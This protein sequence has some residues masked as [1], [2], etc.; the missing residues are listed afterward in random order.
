VNTAALLTAL[1]L[2]SSSLVGRSTLKEVLL[3][4]AAPTAADKRD[5]D[6]GIEKL[7][8][9]AVLTPRTVGIPP[10][11]DEM[12]EYSEIAVASV[13][14]RGAAKA[15]RL[16][17]LLHR[18]A[19]YPALLLTEHGGRPGLSAVHRRWPQS[20]SDRPALDGDIVRV[21]WTPEIDEPFRTPFLEALA[22]TS[23]PRGSLFALYNGW[24]DTLIALQAA[25]R[26]GHFSAGVTAGKI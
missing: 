18:A 5:I 2:P 9:V 22:I 1:D 8:W 3:K 15:T 19:L 13:S 14:M 11:R 20:G 16:V 24:I 4:N 25:R 12:R 10:Y 7:L 17:E 26:T 23:Q 6:E 21:D